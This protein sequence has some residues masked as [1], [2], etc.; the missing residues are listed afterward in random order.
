MKEINF[1]DFEIHAVEEGIEN[2][3]IMG[4]TEDDE[5]VTLLISIDDFE[6][7]ASMNYLYHSSHYIMGSSEYIEQV[8]QTKEHEEVYT[9]ENY[10]KYL[11]DNRKYKTI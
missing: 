7:Y 6:D 1:K 5:Q 4:V 10:L 11:Q 2:I 3:E 8:M 9:D